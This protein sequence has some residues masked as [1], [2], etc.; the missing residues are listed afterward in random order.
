MVKDKSKKYYRFL[1][2][3]YFLIIIIF[4]LGN[5]IVFGET[6]SQ[7]QASYI[8]QQFFNAAHRQVMAKPKLVYNGKRLTTDHLFSPFYVYNHSTG[9]FV[10]ISA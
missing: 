7:K 2:L 10:I 6:V 4:S 8:A 9:G 5:S 1:R 3:V